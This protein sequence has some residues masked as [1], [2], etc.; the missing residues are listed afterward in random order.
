MPNDIELARSAKLSPIAQIAQRAGLK[1][2][3]LIPY[4]AHKA[5][6]SEK[7]F[8]RLENAPQG[9]L[10]LVTAIS[11]TPAGEGKTTTTVG[12]ADAFNLLGY[13]TVLALREPS[14]GPVFG[15]KGG[16]AGGGHAQVL[17]MD[18]INLHF[19]GDIAAVTAAN[20]LLCAMA[21]NHVY[22]G[23]A[24]ELS[25]I[26]FRRVLDMNDRALREMEI[27]LGGKTNGIPRS[28]GFMITA[29]S[30]VMATLCLARDLPDLKERLGDIIAGYTSE[31]RPVTSRDLKADGAMALLLKDAILPN[32]V[33]TMGGS[34]CLMHGGPFAN[35]AH[36]CNTLR[37][38]SLALRLGE[39]AVTEAGFGADLGAEKFFDIVCPAGGFSPSCAVIVASVRALKYNGGAPRES[40][41]EEN[42][43]ALEAGM[44]NLIAHVE[45]IKKFGVPPVVALNRFSTDTPAE[46]EAVK[47]A[48]ASKGVA[49]ALSE[50][51]AKGGEGGTE[52]A[53]EVLRALEAGSAFRT[54][55]PHSLSLKEKT[56][57]IAKEIYGA[58]AVKYSPKA[59]STLADAEKNGFGS[60]PVCVA[61]TQYSF[62]DDPTLLGRPRGFTLHIS[63]AYVSAG[64]GFVVV[65]TGKILTMPGLPALPAA[66]GMDIDEKGRISGL[67]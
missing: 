43:A 53:K 27:G 25:R 4:G 59:E 6:I 61:K 1:R 57:T 31:G 8:K 34:L 18:D 35:I 16:A 47:K 67:F 19:T 62:S 45:N 20:N 7:A 46:L 23:N 54:L 60:L 22:Q 2:S 48:C 28:E 42:P 36:G 21:D 58:L 52:L 50:V 65:Q 55:Y 44:S 33:Q 66:C 15:V 14:L 26:T 41:K 51:Y 13:K 29:A 10:V 3:E 24:P 63:D 32:A 49:C 40:L 9:K 39:I 64:A 12:L 56:E 38:T 37:A 11:P 17:P 30:E 5:K